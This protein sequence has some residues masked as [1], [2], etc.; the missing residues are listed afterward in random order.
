M[1]SNPEALDL[2]GDHLSTPSPERLVAEIFGLL[3]K[4]DAK[5]RSPDISCSQSFSVILTL[6][7]SICQPTWY[8]SDIV[9]HQLL[10]SGQVPEIC[11]ALAPLQPYEIEDLRVLQAKIKTCRDYQ[12]T[13]LA[14]CERTLAEA[15]K[16]VEGC[17]LAL[18]ACVSI[19][20]EMSKASP[21]I[22]AAFD[23]ELQR[24][25]LCHESLGGLLGKMLKEKT[26]VMNRDMQ[27]LQAI[28]EGLAAKERTCQPF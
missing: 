1:A 10:T 14:D 9:P 15:V 20:G 7:C 11:G 26:R 13:I 16:T 24:M 19:D 22:K 8:D 5:G 27:R 28:K 6:A 2:A 17:K 25:L 12:A 18:E 3:S 21:E 4:Y 23:E